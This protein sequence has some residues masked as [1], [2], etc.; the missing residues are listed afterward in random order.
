MPLLRAAPCHQVLHKLSR[1]LM[2]PAHMSNTPAEPQRR[3]VEPLRAGRELGDGVPA[4]PA[5]NTVDEALERGQ[6]L[7]CSG[8]A[9]SCLIRTRARQQRVQQRLRAGKGQRLRC[10]PEALGKTKSCK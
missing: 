6:A 10:M 9:T 8:A 1:R 4:A 7:R 5:L 3:G 2:A